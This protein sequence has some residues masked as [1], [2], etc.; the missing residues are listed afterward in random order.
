[1]LD[2]RKIKSLA[3]FYFD[4]DLSATDVRAI[5]FHGFCQ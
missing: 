1:M 2:C 4:Q 3:A 5:G